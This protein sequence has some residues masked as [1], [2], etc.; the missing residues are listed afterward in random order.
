MA[1]YSAGS[2]HIWAF[3]RNEERVVELGTA[4]MLTAQGDVTDPASLYG[5]KQVFSP[6]KSPIES[7][8]YAVGFDRRG[9][10]DI[11]TVYAGGLQNV[12][13][14]LPASVRRV[15]YISTTGVYGPANGDWVDEQTR[16]EPQREGG[17][18]SFAAEQ[19]LAAHPI[20]RNSVILRLAGIYGPR[21]VPY[22]DKIRAG[23][24][25]AVPISG[26]L[27]LIHVDDAARVVVAAEKWLATQSSSDGPHF[28]CV[29]DGQPVQRGEYY[30]EVARQIGTAEPTFV[31]PEPDSLRAAERAV[32][33]GSATKRC[34][35]N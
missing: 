29:S 28:F 21:R 12:L 22:I 32:I 9:D 20:G 8:L 26:W 27:N 18:A 10:T 5:L 15:I 30:R 35:R 31:A 13:D 16:P 23:E 17:L 25:I 2:E 4:G 6:D 24:P 34:W 11:H 7:L 1:R 3:T 19:I 33:D 14:V